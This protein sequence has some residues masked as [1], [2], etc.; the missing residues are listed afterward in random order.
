MSKN[1]K[2]FVVC[3]A[4]LKKFRAHAVYNGETLVIGMVQQIEATGIFGKWKAPLIKE[5]EERKADGYIVLVE[6]K[7]D[8]ISQYATQY[9]LEDLND[10]HEGSRR[11]NYFDALD[12]FFA[13]ADT[14]NIVFHSDCAQ[15][16][17]NAVSEGGM[18]DRQNDDKG[19]SVYKV[20]WK[21]FNGGFR[22]VLLCVVAALYEPLSE[23]FLD[24]MFQADERAHVI[25]NP[26]LKMRALIHDMNV[27]KGK[28]LEKIR[29]E[30]P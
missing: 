14:G 30:M 10:D 17:I 5:I 29:E 24:V 26:A 22:A 8:Y 16:N 12:W 27:S 4:S 20:D 7:T 11:S 19:R 23:R 2:I 9:L 21:R 6:E 13:L 28:E 15:F 25:A 1:V 3:L 18:V